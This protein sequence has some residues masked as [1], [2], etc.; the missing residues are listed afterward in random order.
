[1]NNEKRIRRYRERLELIET[2]L[3][4]INE[5]TKNLSVDEFE[6]MN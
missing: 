1:M 3:A 2:R 6:K 4:Q 5:W